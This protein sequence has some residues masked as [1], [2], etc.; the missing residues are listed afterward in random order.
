MSETLLCVF[1]KKT[2]TPS[3]ESPTVFLFF[4]KLGMVGI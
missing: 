2:E 3:A 1:I 4:L